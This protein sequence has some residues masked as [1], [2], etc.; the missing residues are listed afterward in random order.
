MANQYD[1][2]DLIRL[3]AAFTVSGTP[4]DPTTVTFKVKTP[5]GTTTT[6][7]YALAQITKDSTGNYHKDISA[8]EAGFW[9]CRME[10]TG[11]V[12]SADEISFEVMP[13]E[14]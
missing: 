10:G 2:G 5:S 9:Y 11:T 6:Y 14:F 8:S 4:T 3:S 1:K 12:E 13:T 7:T